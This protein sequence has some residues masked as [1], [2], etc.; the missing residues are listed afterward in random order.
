MT[1]SPTAALE[2]QLPH[3]PDAER[4]TLGCMLMERS[5]ID[6]AR[7]IL[8]D[9]ADEFFSEKHGE[10]YGFIVKLADVGKPLDGV[11]I[12]DELI[13]AGRFDAL[14]GYE[15][16][17]S[18]VNAVPSALRVNYYAEIVHQKHVG[19]QAV[20]AAHRVLEEAFDDTCN[21][22]EMIEVFD[23]EAR[24]LGARLGGETCSPLAAD[25]EAMLAE[26]NRRDGLKAPGLPTPFWE[27]DSIT[28]GLQIG[29]FTIVA[30]RP[31]VGKSALLLHC[32][33]HLALDRG[34]PVIVYSLEMSRESLTQRLLCSRAGV[35]SGRVRHRN[36][37]ETD[38]AYLGR[39]ESDLR[40]GAPLL[41]D[42][43]R[44]ASIDQLCAR[45]RVAV[46]KYKAKAVF[47]DY[48]QLVRGSP[49][50][51]KQT[52]DIQI[53]TVTAGLADLRGLGV[54]VVAAS[55][56]N[57]APMRDGVKG[58][59]PRLDDLRESGNIEQDADVVYL[60]HPLGDDETDERVQV[61][62]AKQRNGPT[63]YATLRFHKA[64]T[65]FLD[66]GQRPPESDY[67]PV[68]VTGQQG[69]EF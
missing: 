16:L 49:D 50:S 33:E 22:G 37:T 48:L 63:G 3:S 15:F 65:R 57:R 35:D 46:R 36:L 34:C 27:L 67:E 53:G 17:A 31:S 19:R 13:K 6:A 54:T 8:V 60:L 32:A 68:A 41:V 59:P 11:V 1:P 4:A 20:V 26:L 39:A 47:V 25:A 30:A 9:G 45:A 69:M 56:L 28:C 12:K 24:Q 42:V 52:R 58:R 64:T 14:G 61:H 38:L 66:M 51:R 29:E 18:L 44:G 5:A 23:R 43:A 55:Q 21:A 2:R 10:L 62:V 40:K 7:T